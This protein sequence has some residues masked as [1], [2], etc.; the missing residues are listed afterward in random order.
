MKILSLA[1]KEY[2]NSII[3][4]VADFPKPGILFKDITTLLGDAKA[5]EFLIEHLYDR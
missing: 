4:E 3:R 5:F 2:L 1:Q